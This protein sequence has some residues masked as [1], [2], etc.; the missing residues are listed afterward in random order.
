QASDAEGASMMQAA[1]ALGLGG[2]GLLAA[3]IGE[4]FGFDEVEIG[5]S[6]AGLE[7]AALLVGKYLSPRLYVQYSVGLLEPVSTFRVRYQMS[8]RW[9]L[10]TETGAES[11]ADLLFSL[12]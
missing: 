2:G 5:G 7:E 6:G 9:T 12:D 8:R 11:G 3:Q 4:T 10:Q 1:S